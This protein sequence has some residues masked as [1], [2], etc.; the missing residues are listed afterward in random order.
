MRL[1]P[2][3]RNAI[4]ALIAVDYLSAIAAWL[5]FW[6]YRQHF[7]HQALPEIYPYERHWT[8]RDY[9]ISFICIPCFWTVMHYLSGAYFDLYRKSRLVEIYRTVIISIIGTLLVGMIA[10]S[11]DTGSFQYF[12]EITSWYFMTHSVLLLI[13]RM[14]LYRKVKGD[15]IHGR[16]AYNTLIIGDNGKATNIYREIMDNPNVLGN[17]IIGYVNV[18][19]QARPINVAGLH[20]LGHLDQLETII[21]D[22]QIEEVVIALDSSEHKTLEHVLTRLSYRSVIVKVLPDM[23]DIIS[24]SV[25][26]SN[27][28]APVLISIHPELLPDWQRVVKRVMDFG[29]SAL[30]MV[31]LAPV[32]LFAAI[33]VRRSSPGPILYKQ[34]RIGL[35]GQPFYIYKFRSMYMDAEH[36]GPALSKDDDER[37]TP[38]GKIM[39]KWRIDELPQFYNILKGDMSLVGPRPER[40]F[41]I[42]KIVPT[43]PHYKYLHRVKP[44]L[45]SWGMVQY[46]YAENVS[47]M[48]ERMKYDLLYIE[49]CSLVL[50][51]KIM[52]YTVK[53]LFQGRGK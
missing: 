24:G 4:L 19:A 30:A 42:D 5:I 3:K 29:V 52:L 43:H 41:F 17:R 39:R 45:T 37:I 32:Y 15:L 23:Y 10:F 53:V 9:F 51:I 21:D 8:L 7:L 35:F 13:A 44:G 33:K 40:Q 48:I 14:M 2:K 46:G 25:R 26:I 36:A 11:N 12:I 50:D 20:P 22:K 16:I 18:D 28:Y 49:N 6:F 31:V 27:V 34:E 38:W 1:K 47:Q